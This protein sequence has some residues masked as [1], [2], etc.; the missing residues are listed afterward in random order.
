MNIALLLILYELNY[1][2][3][4][5]SILPMR[6]L[7]LLLLFSCAYVT[8]T[9]QK[10]K[11]RFDLEF[12]DALKFKPFTVE[13]ETKGKPTLQT[14]FNVLIIHDFRADKSKL[15][16]AR[17]GEK[18]EDRRFVFPEED[19]DYLGKKINKLFS[20]NSN[21]RDTLVL[22]LKNLWLFKLNNKQV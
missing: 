10:K 4:F 17:A 11:T 14:H 5:L 20:G 8:A 1:L 16:F 22:I 18:I 6:Y 3:F 12:F 7:L 9:S 19:G 2:L 13:V 15:G 21:S